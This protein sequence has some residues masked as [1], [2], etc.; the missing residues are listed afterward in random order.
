LA[1]ASDLLCLRCGAT[2]VVSGALV[3]QP[4]CAAALMHISPPAM[5]T[6]DRRRLPA[7]E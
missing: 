6:D 5:G 2:A 7:F 4:D 3:G 1:D